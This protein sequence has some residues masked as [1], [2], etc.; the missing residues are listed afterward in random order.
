MGKMVKGPWPE[1]VYSVDEVRNLTLVHWSDI[2]EM[3]ASVMHARKLFLSRETIWPD[4]CNSAIELLHALGQAIQKFY[5]FLD[6][7]PQL[8]LA[9]C[10]LRYPLVTGL[11]RIDS[12]INDLKLLITIFRSN[13]R[14]PSHQTFMQLDEI[15]QDVESLLESW[16]DAQRNVKLFLDQTETILNA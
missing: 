4:Q 2:T 3:R 16:K 5:R 15:R 1:L 14:I 13:C 12:Q 9:V 10:P 8:P 11:H 7:T 6:I